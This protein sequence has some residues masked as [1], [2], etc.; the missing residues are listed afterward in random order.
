MLQTGIDDNIP[1]YLVEPAPTAKICRI[2]SEQSQT[3]TIEIRCQKVEKPRFISACTAIWFNI[4]H[5]FK[6]ICQ[7]LVSISTGGYISKGILSK[8]LKR[9]CILNHQYIGCPMSCG[10]CRKE[11]GRIVHFVVYQ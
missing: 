6:N 5:V 4:K 7:K 11:R 10:Y 9:S 3:S 2:T 8:R 1:I